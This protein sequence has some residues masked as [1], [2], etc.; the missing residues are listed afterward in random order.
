[1]NCRW[2]TG[3]SGAWPGKAGFVGGTEA[4]APNVQ[5]TLLVRAER[6]LARGEWFSF[7]LFETAPG[8]CPFQIALSKIRHP[9]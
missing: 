2:L 4:L 5:T 9:A 1:M 8:A 7:A 3:L 6:M